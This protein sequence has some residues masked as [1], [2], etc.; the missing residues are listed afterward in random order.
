MASAT[1]ADLSGRIVKSIEAVSYSVA[2]TTEILPFKIRFINAQIRGY[3]SA[4]PPPIGVAI[5]GVNNY[6]L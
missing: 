4:T 2:T 1:F 3:D 6:I 5:I